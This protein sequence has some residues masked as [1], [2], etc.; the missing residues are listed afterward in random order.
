MRVSGTHHCA[1]EQN[2]KPYQRGKTTNGG[3]REHSM[4]GLIELRIS[5]RL[6]CEETREL[7][8]HRLRLCGV[9]VFMDTRPFPDP[10]D[11]RF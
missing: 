7:F 9:A 3:A 5:H 2:H 8:K 4:S 11:K 6:L 1:S 10:P